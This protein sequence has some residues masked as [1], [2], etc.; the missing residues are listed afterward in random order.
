MSGEEADGKI[1]SWMDLAARIDEWHKGTFI[2]RGVTKMKHELIPRIGRPETRFR[3]N[4]D[5]WA[6]IDIFDK[7]RLRARAFA[8]LTP[9]D[10]PLEWMILAQ[11]HGL[12]TRL[13]DWTL[14]PLIAAYF[15]V[16]QEGKKGDAA[17]YAV[18]RPR[19]VPFHLSEK[20]F[21]VRGTNLIWPPHISPRISAQSAVFTMHYTPPEPYRPEGLQKVIIDQEFCFV[22]K[23]IL[24]DLG[25]G[26][27]TLFPDLN[28]L[29]DEL[30]WE[31]KW[32]LRM[33]TDRPPAEP[34]PPQRDQDGPVVGR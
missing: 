34:G 29:C 9:A 5:K 23:L 21:N 22:L 4:Y 31:L 14:S 20:L 16:E 17:V 33:S 10:S 28:S 13:L 15:A 11:H 26:R 3:Y 24:T 7:F 18:P 1:R 12:P 30:R 19:S 27:A 32:R 25:I 2:F 8:D 6:E